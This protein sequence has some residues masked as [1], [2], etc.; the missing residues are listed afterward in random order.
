MTRLGV[1][2]QRQHRW[3]PHLPPVRQEERQE[4]GGEAASVWACLPRKGELSQ[5]IVYILGQ[6]L[7]HSGHEFTLFN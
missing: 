1:P 3:C 7:N 2:G 4:V 5:E 6:N